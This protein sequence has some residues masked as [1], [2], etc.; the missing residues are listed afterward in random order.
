M[1]IG[2]NTQGARRPLPI[3]L[4]G[5]LS[6]LV[7][8]V[9]LRELM[10]V[11]HGTEMTL[12]FGLAAWLLGG[13]GGSLAAAGISG[14]IGGRRGLIAC[15][16]AVAVLA[17]PCLAFLRAFKPLAGYLPGQGI[18]LGHMALLAFVVMSAPGLIFGAV[19]AFGVRFLEENAQ[20]S[21][22]GSAYW[23]E[24]AGY[25]AGGAAF[26]FF[27]AFK[28]TGAET[29]AAASALAIFSAAIPA[30]TAAARVL[31]IGLSAAALAA[32]LILGNALEIRTQA[33]SYPGY[34]I[35][36]V[37]TSPYGQTTT[38]ER[39]GQ[40]DVFHNGHPAFHHPGVPA[41]AHEE[42]AGWGLLYANRASDILLVGG[43][44]LLP[45]LLGRKGRRVTYAEPDPGL[46]R[47]VRAASLKA[48][49]PV[50]LH[51][52]LEL[53]LKDGRALIE[54]SRQRYDLIIMST[55][56]PS[57]MAL[58]RYYT[59]E[60]FR[61]AGKSLT[62]GGAI[63]LSLSGSQAA[64]DRNKARLNGAVFSALSAAMPRADIIP[65][66]TNIL[67]GTMA[68]EPVPDSVLARRHRERGGSF[69][70][71]SGAHLSY[72]LAERDRREIEKEIKPEAAGRNRD[73]RPS[74][75]SAGTMLWQSV[76]SPGWARA[77]GFLARHSPWLWLLLAAG[78]FGPRLRHGGAAFTAGAASMGLQMLCLWGL[79]IRSGSLYHWVGL[80]NALFMAGTALGAWAYSTRSGVRSVGMLAWEIAFTLW[81]L[82]FLMG[83][84]FLEMPGPAYLACSAV[85]GTILGL[86]FP[87]LV[88]GRAGE[89]GIS[90]GSAAGPVYAWDMAGGF[91]AA[92]AMGVVIIPSW[93]MVP[94]AALMAGIKAVSLRWWIKG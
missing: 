82:A 38:A 12:G 33:W 40:R 18:W 70:V 68:G 5:S 54:S 53:A 80:G 24:A 50:F 36:S 83:Q 88:T 31:G 32:A 51:P 56:P 87:A 73:L 90:E 52:G 66:E 61:A 94:A 91:F 84:A 65:G 58:N 28:L 9:L 79:Q 71:F 45:I 48:S 15:F 17:L 63:V 35:E 25:L 78:F 10:V 72:R 3:F 62:E 8:T 59:E 46:V 74:A 41:M 49:D 29:L 89:R 67:A 47:A 16:I 4:A 11:A 6:I 22:A 19:Y 57:T 69:R 21:P 26:T 44:E 77:Y 13:A 55:P 7:Q 92:L 39:H 64:M 37:A 86:E 85:T 81:A 27:L 42:L 20:G 14:R 75:L 60:F 23:I 30:R 43:P 1:G 93:G 2:R 76:F 34:R